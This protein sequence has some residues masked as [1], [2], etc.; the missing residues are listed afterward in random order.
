MKRLSDVFKDRPMSPI[1]TAIYWIEYVI[2]HKGAHHLRS[3]AV[4][5]PWYQYLLIDVILVVIFS[6]LFFCFIAYRTL[7]FILTLLVGRGI[8]QKVK[9][10]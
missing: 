9:K 1:E 3:P 8:S 2:R 7:K 10:N 5:M 6:I 4:V